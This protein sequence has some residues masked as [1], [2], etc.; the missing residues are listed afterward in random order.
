[1]KRKKADA[2]ADQDPLIPLFDV[3]RRIVKKLEGDAR[4]L[5]EL[6]KDEVF[7][8]RRAREL[9]EKIVEGFF[10]WA[11]R[12]MGADIE[13]YLEE[14]RQNFLDHFILNH[15]HFDPKGRMPRE[16]ERFGSLLRKPDSLS[17]LKPGRRIVHHSRWGQ[18]YEIYRDTLPVLQE[19]KRKTRANKKSCLLAIKEQLPGVP[20][21]EAERILGAAKAFRRCSGIRSMEARAC[22]RRRGS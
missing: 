20:D 9:R 1:M 4:E 19:I 12:R 16:Y 11:I 17:P 7:P 6:G 8:E 21:D 14:G 3:A 15:A 2:T 13:T 18:A 10:D 5:G 22:C